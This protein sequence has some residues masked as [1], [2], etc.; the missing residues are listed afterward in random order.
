M[1]LAL[2]GHNFRFNA[3]ISQ[4]FGEAWL[5]ETMRSTRTDS[6]SSSVSQTSM[7]K[8][9]ETLE[10]RLFIASLYRPA[11]LF[12]LPIRAER[13]VSAVWKVLSFLVWTAHVAVAGH[14]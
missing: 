7:G 10:N 13:A 12:P 11:P 1:C 14:D 4:G 2:T 8:S 3:H 9:D 5:W 6:P